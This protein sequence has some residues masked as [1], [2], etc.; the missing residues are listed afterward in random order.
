MGSSIDCSMTRSYKQYSLPPTEASQFTVP[1]LT[2]CE[3]EHCSI[4]AS[5]I[6]ASASEKSFLPKPHTK[7]IPFYYPVI[8]QTYTHQ[9]RI[10]FDY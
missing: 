2:P 9:L 10:S 3:F 8:L 1:K 4:Q 7:I 5:E 6:R